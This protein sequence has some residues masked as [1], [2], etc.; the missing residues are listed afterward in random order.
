MAPSFPETTF[1]ETTLTAGDLTLRPLSQ[2][3]A[4]DVVSACQDSQ[5]LRWLPLPRPYTRA[6]AEWFIGTFAPTQRDSGGGVVFAIESAG[7][8][9]GAIDL[10]R[11]N[12][13]TKVAEVGYW[14]APWARGRGVASGAARALS[15]WAIRDHG[16]ERVELFAATGNT[17][18]QRAAEKAGFVREGVARNAC[19][20]NGS[21]MDMVLFSLVPDDLLRSMGSGALIEGQGQDGR[22]LR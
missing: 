19:C 8:L 21:R 9:A 2:S 16:F 22:S 10:K 14:V 11:A 15:L 6:D 5:T 7:R 1:P 17:G 20:V 4:D 12:W 3:D 13:V 18:S